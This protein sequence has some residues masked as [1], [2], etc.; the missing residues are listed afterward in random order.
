MIESITLMRFQRH[1]K[2]TVKFDPHLTCLT[3]DTGAGKSTVIR[4]L[5]W[6][7]FNRPSGLEMIK[8]GAAVCSCVLRVDGRVVRRKRG[9]R[10]NVYKLDDAVFKAFGQNVPEEIATLLNVSDINFQAQLD[11]PFWLADPAPK[12][13]RE[14]NA[15]VNLSVIDDTLSNAA[16]SLRQA[17]AAWE[18]SEQRL[19]AASEELEALAHVPAFLKA[20]KEAEALE[21]KVLQKRNRLTALASRLEQAR[22]AREI[23]QRSSDAMA[24]AL[25]LERLWG[26]VIAGR[27][28]VE[29]LRNLLDQLA[30]AKSKASVA[31]E[32]VPTL[33]Y[34]RVIE[35]R[36]RLERLRSL[37]RA[38]R[39]E[40]G[41]L[42][43]IRN[44]ATAASEEI[45]RLAKD[46]PLCGQ[47]LP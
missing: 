9:K 41:R 44:E 19:K 33:L 40:E 42:C 38:A 47:R 30:R 10:T 17:K 26:R 28:R 31:V 18:V 2:L 6:L 20:V 11:S 1:D 16:S 37:V 23:V 3:G 8:H 36:Q 4:A 14:L 5:M 35:G 24:E 29:R 46:C 43:Q 45:K 34:Q 27:K 15:V 7:S 25:A 32:N 13:S 22:A 12:V 21:V 39:Q